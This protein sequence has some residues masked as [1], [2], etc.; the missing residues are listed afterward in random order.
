MDFGPS[1]SR[2]FSLEMP[3]FVTSHP[4]ARRWAEPPR[5]AP[6]FTRRPHAV[7]TAHFL[8]GF[9]ASR[10]RTHRRE[11]EELE[12]GPAAWAD[13]R[14]LARRAAGGNASEFVFFGRNL[15]NG[16]ISQTV[17]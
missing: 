4:L 5:E 17:F 13:G 9:K 1:H 16:A 2:L 15:D 10:Q 11:K 6:L 7:H 14:T 12:V 3:S 8:K